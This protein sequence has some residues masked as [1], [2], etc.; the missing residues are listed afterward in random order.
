[1]NSLNLN[2]LIL[3]KNSFLNFLNKVIDPWR[4]ELLQIR[5]FYYLKNTF[6]E[7]HFW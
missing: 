4:I 1:M 3:K 5:S 2:F 7:N 6:L